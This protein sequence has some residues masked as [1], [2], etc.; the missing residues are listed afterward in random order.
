MCGYVLIN[1]NR[2]LLR[3]ESPVG[4]TYVTVAENIS[5]LKKLKSNIQSLGL[6]PELASMIS[7]LIS[8]EPL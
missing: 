8:E 4:F 7:T 2:L 6:N 5:D 1:E 3:T